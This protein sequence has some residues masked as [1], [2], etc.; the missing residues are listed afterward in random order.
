VDVGEVFGRWLAWRQ[1]PG[2]P[3]GWTTRRWLSV[4]AGRFVLDALEGR[5]PGLC[6]IAAGDTMKAMLDAH[7][8]QS[9]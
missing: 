6:P 7:D 1:P 8:E 9:N 2:L 4:I 3:P 5:L